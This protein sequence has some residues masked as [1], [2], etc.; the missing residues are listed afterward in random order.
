M[1]KI[2]DLSIIENLTPSSIL[3]VMQ[4]PMKYMGD[5]THYYQTDPE[6]IRAFLNEISEFPSAGEGLFRCGYNFHISL[7]GEKSSPI[8][9]KVCFDCDRLYVGNWGYGTDET[10]FTAILEKHCLKIL[11]SGRGFNSMHAR[12]V[13]IKKA[14]QEGEL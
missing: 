3:M 8:D 13:K 10:S 12:K 6:S 9:L 14:I 1:N 5:L 7:E 4:D 11:Q 2:I